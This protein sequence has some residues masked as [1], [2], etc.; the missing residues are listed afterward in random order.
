[1]SGFPVR[2]CALILLFMNIFQDAVAHIESR[3][4]IKANHTFLVRKF[5]AHAIFLMQNQTN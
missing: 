5:V 3:C 2:V 1:M 4:V